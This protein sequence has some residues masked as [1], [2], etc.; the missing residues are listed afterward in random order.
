MVMLEPKKKVRHFF[1]NYPRLN[2]KRGE[3]I[4]N[5]C[6]N[7]NKVFYLEK[8]YVKQY[9]LSKDGRIKA[10]NIYKPGAYFPIVLALAKYQNRYYFEA[11]NAVTVREAPVSQVL[12]FIQKDPFITA[13]LLKRFYVGV[14]GVLNILESLM[15]ET[16]QKKLAAFLLMLSARFGETCQKGTR[17]V[18]PLTHQDLA[19]FTGMIRETVSFEMKKLQQKGI[20]AKNRC[21]KTITIKSLSA[22]KKI[23]D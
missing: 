14:D 11:I 23:L 8:G 9:L 18:I 22:L 4:F 12:E 3:I 16:S 21:R 6:Q 1:Q 2:F 20:I 15:Y 19:S 7:V 13:E 5:P 17:I 10:V